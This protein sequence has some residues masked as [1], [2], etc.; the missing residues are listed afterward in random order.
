MKRN[1]CPPLANDDSAGLLK[2]G[3]CITSFV[4]N[5]VWKWRNKD[6]FTYYEHG[7]TQKSKNNLYIASP[8]YSKTRIIQRKLKEEGKK[9]FKIFSVLPVFKNMQQYKKHCI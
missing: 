2:H 3:L 4:C 9:I 1:N 5:L 7:Y 8:I 6:C